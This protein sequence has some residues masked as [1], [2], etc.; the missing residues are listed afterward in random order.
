MTVA[1]RISLKS[2]QGRQMSL[3]GIYANNRLDKSV[4]CE[5]NCADSLLRQIDNPGAPS[6]S[7]P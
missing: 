6:A 7:I 4:G 2:P 1:I 3:M 5:C